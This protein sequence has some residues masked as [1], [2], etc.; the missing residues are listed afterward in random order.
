MLVFRGGVSAF[1]L[2]FGVIFTSEFCWKFEFRGF[3]GDIF[4]TTIPIVRLPSLPNVFGGID[5]TPK[6]TYPKDQPHL[7]SYDWKGVE[8]SGLV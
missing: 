5:W 6:N 3:D 7:S 8:I 1:E 2:F 4:D